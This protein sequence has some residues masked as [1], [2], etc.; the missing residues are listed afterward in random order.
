MSSE[1]QDALKESRMVLLHGWRIGRHHV[2]QF[3]RTCLHPGAT[4]SYLLA[5]LLILTPAGLTYASDS[6]ELYKSF[7]EEHLGVDYEQISI[8]VTGTVAEAAERVLDYSYPESSI[9][10][11]N[12]REKNA[13]IIK[14]KTRS[15]SFTAGFVT[16]DSSIIS[17]HVLEYRHS[18][19]KGIRK[20]SFTDQFRNLSFS[21]NS[22]LN[23]HI[24]AV[25]GAT[26]SSKAFTKLA[27]LVLTLETVI[28]RP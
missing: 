23:R 21:E 15:G 10:L 1:P 2:Q 14:G 20:S 18:H 5:L 19:G 25:S 12:S 17:A 4:R 13:Y 24:D 28:S 8:A 3:C 11:F 16:A 26:L 6:M 22:T 9:I 7:A 27:E